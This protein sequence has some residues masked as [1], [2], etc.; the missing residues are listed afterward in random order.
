MEEKG[1][2][3]AEE[4]GWVTWTR[5]AYLSGILAVNSKGPLS[6]DAVK[7]HCIALHCTAL[8][9]TAACGGTYTLL[10]A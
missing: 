9:C 3:K 5:A 8:H 2:R 10:F 1:Q 4:D 7:G 6:L